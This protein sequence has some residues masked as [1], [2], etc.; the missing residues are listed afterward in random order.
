MG[1]DDEKAVEEKAVEE[2]MVLYIGCRSNNKHPMFVNG[3]TTIGQFKK[4]LLAEHHGSEIDTVKYGKE[5]IFTNK[6]NLQLARSGKVLLDTL[7]VADY[8]IHK[9]DIPYELKLKFTLDASGA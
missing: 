3:S 2:S 4:Q 8:N 1:S 5:Q 7:T 6:H 9:S